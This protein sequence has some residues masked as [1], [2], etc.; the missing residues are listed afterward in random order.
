[1]SEINENLIRELFKSEIFLL[2]IYR[3]F[4]NLEVTSYIVNLKIKCVHVYPNLSYSLL[5]MKCLRNVQKI[6]CVPLVI[7]FIVGIP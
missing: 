1:M 2:L 5:T 3:K 7:F 6:I 4:H